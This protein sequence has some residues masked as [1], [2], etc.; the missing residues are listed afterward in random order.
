MGSGLLA[1][2]AMREANRLLEEVRDS[3]VTVGVDTREPPVKGIPRRRLSYVIVLACLMAVLL[4]SLLLGG[5]A[6]EPWPLVLRIIA[7]ATLPLMF[8]AVWR[9]G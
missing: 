3:D 6:P 4:T 8:W 7:L 5:S 1:F 2:G 9:V